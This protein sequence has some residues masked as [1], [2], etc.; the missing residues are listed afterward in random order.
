MGKSKLLVRKCTL[1]GTFNFAVIWISKE[2]TT[3][4]TPIEKIPEGVSPV[5]TR[6]DFNVR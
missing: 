4:Y 5:K 6:K 1:R 2:V 3:F